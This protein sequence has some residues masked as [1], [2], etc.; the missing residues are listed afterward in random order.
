MKMKRVHPY[1]LSVNSSIESIKPS[2][3]NQQ[4]EMFKINAKALLLA[5]K[6]DIGVSANGGELSQSTAERAASDTGR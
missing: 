4:L 5:D 1:R 3:I 6:K 2:E